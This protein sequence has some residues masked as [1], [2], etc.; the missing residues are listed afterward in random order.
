M[1]SHISS[2][3]LSVPG[4][5]HNVSMINHQHAA[6]PEADPAAVTSLG[7]DRVQGRQ[8]VVDV[9]V[10]A[11]SLGHA[12]VDATG[13]RGSSISDYDLYPLIESVAHR[14]MTVRHISVS[15]PQA[16]MGGDGPDNPGWAGEV[17][18]RWRQWANR[19]AGLLE[20]FPG[21]G[22][23]VLPGGF[24]RNGE[25][26]V[27]DLVAWCALQH[28]AHIADVGDPEHEAVVVVSADT[29]M[30][31]LAADAAPVRLF[32]AGAFTPG[33][34][35]RL[36]VSGVPFVQ[37]FA[38]DLVRLATGDDVGEVADA[39]MDAGSSL[40]LVSGVDAH[41]AGIRSGIEDGDV[42]CVY[43]PPNGGTF[44]ASSPL[45]RLIDVQDSSDNDVLASANT[46]V[47]ADPYGLHLAT[48]RAIGVG[49]LAT[50]QTI[51]GVLEPMGWDTPVAVL[52]VVPDLSAAHDGDGTLPDALVEAW[53][54]RDAELDGLADEL[55]GDGDGLTQSRRAELRVMQG[56]GSEDA[57]AKPTIKRLST[58]M[59]ADLWRTFRWA[60][61]ANVVV[62]TEAP[63]IEWFLDVLPV[64]SPEVRR[65][66]RLG[67]HS[68]RVT[69][70]DPPGGVDLEPGP[71]V[72]LT[73]HLAA[74]LVGVVDRPYARN[75]RDRLGDLVRSDVRVETRGVDPESGGL[76]VRLVPVGGE[77]D[78]EGGSVTAT[79]DSG[80]RQLQAVETVLHAGGAGLRGDVEHLADVVE[81]LGGA[82]GLRFDPS[83]PCAV[84]E[85]VV[86]AGGHDADHQ[87]R[88]ARVVSRE[89]HRL[90]VDVDFD[91]VADIGVTTGHDTTMYNPDDVVTIQ[92]LNDHSRRWALVDPGAS[93]VDRGEPHVVLRLVGPGDGGA[94]ATDPNTGD[95]G[96]VEP[97]PG[98]DQVRSATHLLA[99]EVGR[100]DVGTVQW[101]AISSGLAHLDDMLGR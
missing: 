45:N 16:V 75:L 94:W 53:W 55:D 71:V 87:P 36:A 98:E 78:V 14:G 79:G 77:Q 99:V 64:V 30:W 22:F 80:E 62:A 38:P 50:P 5:G 89:G 70:V 56:V 57:V 28:A 68:R 83:A 29:D 35:S 61:Q 52:A 90:W 39:D 23:D 84:P 47:V 46:V 85:V 31:H 76:V 19:Q 25:V 63:D 3:R 44:Q 12:V 7:D 33:Q 97:L 21:V 82:V 92:P 54:G 8:L 20:E 49:G 73:E 4:L 72:V 59:I 17:V 27:D 91:G 11:S 26:G 95:N 66:V 9:V 37:L 2:V 86:D 15:A 93:V 32:V 65:P 81:R 41:A 100:D 10:D 40:T 96:W 24:D 60:P 88:P 101:M 18:N 43:R 42:L 6:F 34:M 74:E 58:G 67:L 48:R 13:G 1:A 51:R 69:V